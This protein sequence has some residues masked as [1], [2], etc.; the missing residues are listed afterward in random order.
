MITRF[1]YFG[2]KLLIGTI[3]FIVKFCMCEPENSDFKEYFP[4]V[5]DILF[6]VCY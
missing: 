4:L 2:E 5:F 3:L 6:K 1:K